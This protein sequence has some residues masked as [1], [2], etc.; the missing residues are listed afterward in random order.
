MGFICVLLSLGRFISLIGSAFHFPF[1]WTIR[2]HG[3][4]GH[5]CCIPSLY[6]AKSMGESMAG[7][8]AVKTLNH[9]LS[10][11]F[12]C[13]RLT[14]MLGVLYLRFHWLIFSVLLHVLGIVLGICCDIVERVIAQLFAGHLLI[15]SRRQF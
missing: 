4:Y 14:E 3:G 12:D 11:A 15:A 10:G 2:W 7:C 5:D 13:L 6:F 9:C 8:N 1:L